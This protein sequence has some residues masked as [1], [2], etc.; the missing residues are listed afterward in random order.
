MLPAASCSNK[1]YSEGFSV[2]SVQSSYDRDS[3]RSARSL[4]LPCAAGYSCVRQTSWFVLPAVCSARFDWP[5][6]QTAAHR[7]VWLYSGAWVWRG[8]P[9]PQSGWHTEPRKH[10]DQ[11]R[12]S[13]WFYLSGVFRQDSYLHHWLFALLAVQ[14]ELQL[15]HSVLSF[16]QLL[17]S[18]PLAL[19]ALSLQV[20]QLFGALL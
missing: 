12:G 1:F 17:P 14:L 2:L 7:A 18:P 9:P 13:V 19:I 5:A 4:L 15:L 11:Q 16:P 10:P 8:I 3:Q 6:S 20:R